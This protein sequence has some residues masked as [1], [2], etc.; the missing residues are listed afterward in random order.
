MKYQRSL[1][2]ECQQNE[3]KTYKYYTDSFSVV[4]IFKHDVTE[5]SYKL[6]LNWKFIV[7]KTGFTLKKV[8]MECLG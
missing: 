4:A 2:L 1:L 8:E 6:S 3:A 5:F 7:E